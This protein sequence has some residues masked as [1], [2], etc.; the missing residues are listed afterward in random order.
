MVELTMPC[1]LCTRTLDADDF[2]PKHGRFHCRDCFD[3]SAE[4]RTGWLPRAQRKPV[5]SSARGLSRLLA[6]DP[7]F[8]SGSDGPITRE[9]TCECGTLFTQ[10][11]LSERFLT[12]VERAGRKAL[13]AVSQQ[14]PGYYVPVHCPRCERID[15]NRQGTID[16]HRNEYPSQPF[17][18]RDAAD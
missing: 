8:A 4:A 15:L 7:M 16:A 2:D 12:M 6:G 17:G 5:V 18:E 9:R 10:R 3:T 13:A 11:L 14:I 1:P